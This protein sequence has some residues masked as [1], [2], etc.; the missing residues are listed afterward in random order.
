MIIQILEVYT[1]GLNAY[2]KYRVLD[3]S[4]VQDFVDEN[5]PETSEE[6]Y[7]KRVI[8]MVV[9]NLR[10]EVTDALRSIDE[11]MGEVV[12]DSIYNGCIMLNPGFDVNRWLLLSIQSAED[13]LTSS[14]PEQKAIETT[15][16]KT[17][18]R[19][20]KTATKHKISKAKFK[21]LEHHLKSNVIGQ[22]EAVNSV[23]SALKRSIVGLHD[24]NRP[25]GVF[26][27][28]GPSGT[29][30]TH[31]AKTLHEY[32]YGTEF[33]IV[34]VDCGEY[35]HKHE[36]QKLIGA[37]AGYV[38]YDEGGHLTNAM[39]KN[40]KTVVLLDEVEKAHPDIWDTF[41]RV[42]DEGL[43]TD[44]SGEDISFR[45]TVIIMTSNLGNKEIVSS[46]LNGK[47]VGFGSQVDFVIDDVNL[48]SRD[49][50]ERVTKKAIA[51]KFRPEFM[52]RI[53]KYVIFNH[54]SKED[55]FT[56][57]ELEFGK[58]QDKLKKKGI[59][60]HYDDASLQEM[61]DRGINSVEGAR[62]LSKIRRDIIEDKISDVLLSNLRMPRGT[63]INV[64]I[65]DDSKFIVTYKK[66]ERKKNTVIKKGLKNGQE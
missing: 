63:I 50:I 57:A 46:T 18:K 26:L 43:L 25:L 52:N 8:E 55:S 65:D 33:E 44:A 53:D 7:I 64:G 6:D 24:E 56:I 3:P 1:P 49:S 13:N 48:P 59:T 20:K 16:K 12:I 2:I 47:T 41:L 60:L 17:R 54:L 10:P 38:G 5:K 32:L 42:F 11:S 66:P 4:V 51:K 35:Q 19:T 58:I 62:G 37:P 14:S 31:L 27:F 36:N 23:V 29:G 39:K 30:K 34:R 15:E 28:I 21:G 9:Y 45:D 61:V 40:N 22:D